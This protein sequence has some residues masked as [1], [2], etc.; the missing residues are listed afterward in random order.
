MG[1][2][3]LKQ[4]TVFFALLLLFLAAIPAMAAPT[5]VF[6]PDDSVRFII[7][8]SLDKQLVTSVDVSLSDETTI[9]A[10]RFDYG[11]VSTD[12]FGLDLGIYASADV[13]ANGAKV[14]FYGEVPNSNSPLTAVT[15]HLYS[16]AAA[17]NFVASG[18]LSV[19]ITHRYDMTFEDA[20]AIVE[21]ESL[22]IQ[23]KVTFDDNLT[24]SED[25]ILPLK[26]FA[27]EGKSDGTNYEDLGL[28]LTPNAATSTIRITSNAAK[29]GTETYWF[30]AQSERG[31]IPDSGFKITV[32][33]HA[34]SFSTPML[35]AMATEEVDYYVMYVK[36]PA[37][38]PL[39]SFDVV[40]AIEDDDYNED[41]PTDIPTFDAVS[42]DT[43]TLRWNGLS[44][45]L[46]VDASR[47]RI[48]GTAVEQWEG[49][50]QLMG[51]PQGDS[52]ADD[53]ALLSDPLNIATVQIEN[54]DLLDTDN[55]T[56]SDPNHSGLSRMTLDVVNT[57]TIPLRDDFDD[58][59]FG[60]T[61]RTPS[62]T[63]EALSQNDTSI[64]TSRAAGKNLVIRYTPR[65]VG[66][67]IFE[68]LYEKDGMA[69]YEDSLVGAGNIYSSGSSGC[70][71]GFAVFSLAAAALF[72]LRK[73]R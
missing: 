44:I 38:M 35:L 19:K 71:A 65:E 61:V 68:I 20:P 54:G 32:T 13:T 47:L 5:V 51:W 73:K 57:M 26:S 62:R 50:L 12:I 39:A 52:K 1:Y 66:D 27:L 53:P 16:D 8:T 42:S 70:N 48:Y 30:S 58:N 56:L 43:G 45:D 24:G 10:I 9:G 67:Y 36:K 33:E 3:A 25:L 18:D 37:E 15:V 28:T 64:T 59:N 60:M 69:Y 29:L 41:D 4:R 23:V 6:E 72:A 21:G 11:N 17:T 7:G 14:A 40:M 49:E 2:V 55:A 22:D 46:E 31:T 63:I 34:L